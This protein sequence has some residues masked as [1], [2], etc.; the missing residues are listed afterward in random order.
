MLERQPHL[1][2]PGLVQ[3]ALKFA[4]AQMRRDFAI[5]EDIRVRA[6]V[7]VPVSPTQHMVYYSAFMEDDADDRLTLEMNVGVAAMC[8]RDKKPV[9]IK[10]SDPGEKGLDKYQKALVWPRIKTIFALPLFRPE[11]V[12]H[13]AAAPDVIAVLNFD[14]DGDISERL[15]TPRG[16]EFTYEASNLVTTAM[17]PSRIRAYRP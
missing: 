17:F 9:A 2:L 1:A 7:M 6:N 16:Y 14:S 13:G 11:P 12:V 15:E 8:Y 10:L 4:V 5:A 3:T